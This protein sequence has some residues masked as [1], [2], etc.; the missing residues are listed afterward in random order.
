MFRQEGF[1]SIWISLC[2]TNGSH[3][4]MRIQYP[5]SS[6]AYKSVNP[7]AEM[8]PWMRMD[9]FSHNIAPSI[10]F[11][12][13]SPDVTASRDT[14]IFVSIERCPPVNGTRR[15]IFTMGTYRPSNLTATLLDYGYYT[16]MCTYYEENE[17]SSLTYEL[18]NESK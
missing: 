10:E 9:S 14:P 1:T 16:S 17:P 3:A 11:L 12:N 15:K 2:C 4:D 6:I 8:A 13:D 18:T 7:R 5:R